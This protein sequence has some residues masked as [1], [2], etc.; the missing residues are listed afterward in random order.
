MRILILGILLAFMA[1]GIVSAADSGLEMPPGTKV[2]VLVE[3]I[4]NDA[5][6]IGLTTEFITGKAELQLRKNGV[7]VGTKEESILS[8]SY[9]YVNCGVTG[10]A[11]A[12]DIDFRRKVFYRV[13]DVIHS[14]TGS[15]YHTGGQ[16]THGAN[17]RYVVQAMTD[18]ID[19]FS[20]DYLRSNQQKTMF[21]KSNAGDGK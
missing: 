11:F 6:A 7:P 12:I 2:Y 18:L 10:R 16:G 14:V 5:K 13:G 1:P 4:S 17:S 20:N 3:D 8:G 15:T 19:L 21:N 9:L